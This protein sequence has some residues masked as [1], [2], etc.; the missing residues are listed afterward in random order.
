MKR[1]A[2]LNPTGQAGTAHT[3]NR[4]DGERV[5]RILERAAAEQHRLNQARAET[6]ALEAL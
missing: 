4:F 6:Y 1:S 3:D 2:E 5:R